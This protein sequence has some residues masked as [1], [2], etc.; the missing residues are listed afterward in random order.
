MPG[1]IEVKI[2]GGDELEK[3][4]EDVSRKIAKAII[5]SALRSAAGIWREEMKDRAKKG[6]HVWQGSKQGRSREFG[7]VS[8]HIGMKF[9]VRGDDLEATAQVGPMRKFFW[10]LFMEF[11]TRKMAA[12]P[13]IRQSFESRKQDVLN[14]FIEV[15]KEKVES[16]GGE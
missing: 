12:R 8:G 11:G 6:W 3:K 7:L 10:S 9:A 1:V 16:Q 14:K 15:A 4:L 13:F 2:T 5:R